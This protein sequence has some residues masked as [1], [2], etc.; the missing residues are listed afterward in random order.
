MDPALAQLGWTDEQWNRICTTVTEE[1][2]KARVAAQILPV[3]GP[4]DGSTVAI[5]RF[6][7]SSSPVSSPPV[8]SLWPA[9]N[10][11]AV[12]SNPTLNLT[13]ISVNVPLR[14]HEISDPELKAALTMFR[15]AAN[16]VAR[17]ED[18]M[19]F[20]GRGPGVSGG[21]A[22]V[23]GPLN[24]VPSV[25]GFTTDAPIF[26]DGVYTGG[27]AVVT[28]TPSGAPP[29]VAGTDVINA[30]TKAIGILEAKG[31]LGPFALALGQELFDA[32]HDPS[33]ALVLP[34]DR[35]LPLIQGPL[36]R[37]ST[38]SVAMG[39]LIAL[40]GDPVE[41]VVACD[42]N[43]QYLQTTVEPRYVFRVVERVALRIKERDA[44]ATFF[45]GS[46][47]GPHRPPAHQPRLAGVPV[48]APPP[49][50][51]LDGFKTK[52][53]V[54]GQNVG[55]ITLT[56]KQQTELISLKQ[57]ILDRYA[58]IRFQKVAPQDIR[59]LSEIQAALDNNA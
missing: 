11:L 53:G 38:G 29:A 36:V 42:I 17:I 47:G 56:S 44:I 9:T 32:A 24:G 20:N 55:G 2:Q 31:Q 19:L 30:V 6:T 13:T 34:R 59:D 3:V 21:N 37:A 16:Y 50:N 28:V 14:G 51:L 25:F 52:H 39:A 4:E 54:V 8:T 33:V 18:A 7:L 22:L 1:A 43:V 5:P 23:G 12:D 15:R 48:S 46:P 41:L 58:A 45:V 26:D 10:R 49:L 35:I 40:S 57:Q 27:G